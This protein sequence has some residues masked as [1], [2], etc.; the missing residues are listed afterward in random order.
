MVYFSSDLATY[1]Y[2][3]VGVRQKDLMHLHQVFFYLYLY[4]FKQKRAESETDEYNNEISHGIK[5]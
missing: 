5:S 2:N 1:M 3:L 4:L